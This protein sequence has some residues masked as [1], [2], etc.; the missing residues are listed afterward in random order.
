MLPFNFCFHVCCIYEFSF[1]VYAVT[2]IRGARYNL[3]QIQ[4]SPLALFTY[5]SVLHNQ[6][7]SPP[8]SSRPSDAIISNYEFQKLLYIHLQ[9]V[10]GQSLF[11]VEQNQR[12][13]A[14]VSNSKPFR[15][16]SASSIRTTTNP[17]FYKLYNCIVNIF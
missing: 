11:S 13:P 10:I 15:T 3:C 6:K 7:Y 16:L 2:Q 12:I 9:T 8:N 14:L 17:A 1:D 4:H 5:S